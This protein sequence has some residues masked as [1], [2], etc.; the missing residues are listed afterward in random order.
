L[1]SIKTVIKDQ[2]NYKYSRKFAIEFDELYAALQHIVPK[3][4]SKGRLSGI[5]SRPSGGLFGLFG[6]AVQ[7]GISSIIGDDDASGGIPA[8]SVQKKPQPGS[9]TPVATHAV[10]AAPVVITKGPEPVHPIVP[11]SLAMGGTS[12]VV[13]VQPPAFV[14]LQGGQDLN[15]SPFAVAAQIKAPA[16]TMSVPAPQSVKPV[17]DTPVEV[18]PAQEV[19]PVVAPVLTPPPFATPSTPAAT[20]EL[21]EP[22]VRESAQPAEPEKPVELPPMQ[23]LLFSAP[24]KLAPSGPKQR[25]DRKKGASAQAA[26]PLPTFPSPFGMPGLNTFTPSLAEPPAQSPLE[27]AVDSPAKEPAEQPVKP[28]EK[29][30]PTAA[31]TPKPEPAAVPTFMAPPQTTAIKPA[32][33]KREVKNPIAKKAAPP[34]M[35]KPM[36]EPEP[37]P[38]PGLEPEAEPIYNVDSEPSTPHSDDDEFKKPKDDAPATPSRLAM[39]NPL[40]WFKR[41]PQTNK[42][43]KMKLGGENNMYY[44]DELGMWVERVRR[45]PLWMMF[46]IL[47]LCCCRERKRKRSSSNRATCHHHLRKRRF[48]K[49]HRQL[50]QVE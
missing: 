3:G 27:A 34:P 37:E 45:P 8:S 14:S 48:H 43:A 18:K 41:S 11:P 29:E 40:N 24:P 26:T 35:P 31:D 16:P 39:L 32:N 50:P 30:P 33:T 47:T 12:I 5:L 25:K 9:A 44:N 42:P 46:S 28:A 13:P 1:E 21:T 15:P 49:H 6:K 4:G 38:E 7:Y 17:V 23:P 2:K 22:E 10:N 20:S 36:P 19:A